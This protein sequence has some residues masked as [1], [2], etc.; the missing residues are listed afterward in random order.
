[1]LDKDIERYGC[2][3]CHDEL[4]Q[5]CVPDEGI[6]ENFCSVGCQLKFY[7]EEYDRLINKI[8]RVYRLYAD[9]VIAKDKETVKY[10]ETLDILEKI[11]AIFNKGVRDRAEKEGIKE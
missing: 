10:I 3:Q 2:H 4:P 8:N 5:V 6:D 9:M 1:M 7:Q 11:A